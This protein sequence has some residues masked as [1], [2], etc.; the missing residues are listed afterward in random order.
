MSS[1]QSH[2]I[3]TFAENSS[4]SYMFPTEKGLHSPS[5]TPFRFLLEPFDTLARLQIITW[6]QSRPASLA[7]HLGFPPSIVLQPQDGKYVA[8]REAELLWNR[9]AIHI[10]CFRYKTIFS[11]LRTR[12]GASYI[13]KSEKEISNSPWC[14]I[15]L[16]SCVYFWPSATL[17][18]RVLRAPESCCGGC[19][20]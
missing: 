5:F 4:A 9:G 8:L 17:L 19:P 11:T 16:P 14:K 20:P 12:Q 1:G 2:D 6:Y 18:L 10:Q 7:C 15:G 3:S 13:M